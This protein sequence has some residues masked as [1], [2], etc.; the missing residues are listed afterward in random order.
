MI[1]VTVKSSVYTCI[2]IVVFVSLVFTLGLLDLRRWEPFALSVFFVACS[3]LCLT[4]LTAPPRKP[5]A[6]GLGP[7]VRLTPGTR[8]LST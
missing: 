6:D 3:L 4:S 5:D 2:G 7:D 1:G 8:N